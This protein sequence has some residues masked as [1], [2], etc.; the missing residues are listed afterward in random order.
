MEMNDVSVKYGVA[1]PLQSEPK[2]PVNSTVNNMTINAIPSCMERKGTQQHSN[3]AF[4]TAST[5]AMPATG[6]IAIIEH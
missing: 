5:C 3:A 4:D 2:T 6:K 1:T